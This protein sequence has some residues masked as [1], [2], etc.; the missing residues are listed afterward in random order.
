MKKHRNTI[1][2]DKALGGLAGLTTALT[3]AAWTGHAI[4]WW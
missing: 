4:G 2:I 1:T 3:T